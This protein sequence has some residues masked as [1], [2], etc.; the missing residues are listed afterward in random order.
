MGAD[1]QKNPTQTDSSA[2]GSTP[3]KI[4]SNSSVQKRSRLQLDGI[5]VP[6]PLNFGGVLHISLGIYVAINWSRYVPL[7]GPALLAI[8]LCLMTASSVLFH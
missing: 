8:H 4:W 3:K 1:V 2:S 7:R 6:M 5:C